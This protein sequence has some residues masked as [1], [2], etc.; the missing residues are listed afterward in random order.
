[1]S[2]PSSCRMSVMSVLSPSKEASSPS[3]TRSREWVCER[4]RPSRDEYVSVSTDRLA[5]GLPLAPRARS[6]LSGAFC[7]LWSPA[8]LEPSVSS[9]AAS[10]ERRAD[11]LVYV[12]GN[13]MLI[14][15]DDRRLEKDETVLTG[16]PLAGSSAWAAASAE[17]DERRS[18]EM[19]CLTRSLTDGIAPPT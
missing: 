14:E 2:T 6:S 5:D 11:E 1:M 13:E 10:E 17:G 16:L 12:V 4:A 18:K 19:R 3:S 9:R 7:T 15:C 8:A